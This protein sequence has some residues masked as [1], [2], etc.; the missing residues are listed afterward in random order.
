MRRS[1]A[2]VLSL[3]VAAPAI[4]T[5]YEP[6]TVITTE[7]IKND[8]KRERERQS[9]CRKVRKSG[10]NLTKFLP[11]DEND[12]DRLVGYSYLLEAGED[13]CLKNLDLAIALVEMAFEGKS[14]LDASDSA[15]ARLNELLRQRGSPSDLVRARDLQRYL[16]IRGGWSASDPPAWSDAE[17]RDFAARDDVWAYTNKLIENQFVGDRSAAFQFRAAVLLDPLS[18]RF[19][20][21]AAINL[22]ERRGDVGETVKAAR[23]LLDGRLVPAD[24]PRAEAL[25]W[26]VAMHS[27]EA[28]LMLIDLHQSEL[29]NKD[30][31]IRRPLV[32]RLAPFI[33]R[34]PPR[35]QTLRDRIVPFVLPDL[36]DPD[37]VVQ[38]AAAALLANLSQQGAPAAIGPL[39]GWLE[40]QLIAGDP[41]RAA[42]ARGMLARLVMADI[43]PARVAMTR[44]YARHGGLVDAGA[45]TPDPAKPVAMDKYILAMDYPTRALREERSGVVRATAVFGPDGKVLLI[46]ITGSS[47]HAD[48]DQAVRSTLQRR[49]RRSWPEY[50]GRYVR[51][52]LPPIQFRIA[53]CNNEGPITKPIEEAVLVDGRCLQTLIQNTPVI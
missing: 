32:A 31:A 45:W 50:P 5:S 46:D 16:W 23:V 26:R 24:P 40:P 8:R 4:A 42:G 30:A 53:D 6:V 36:A 3:A 35:S 9:F 41:V 47:G 34:D 1:M 14:P 7:S 21:A 43:A 2:I 52:K 15:L 48:L 10:G 29:A 12:S 11:K 49:M 19:D 17:R 44:E 38:A 13:G 25:L 20:P 33:V 39:L 37:L 18:N 51:V 27:D 22:F 28:V